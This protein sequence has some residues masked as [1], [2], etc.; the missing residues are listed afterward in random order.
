MLQALSVS[1]GVG[2]TG[3][4]TG[5]PPHE[6]SLTN[7]STEGQRWSCPL[8]W[9]SIGRPTKG[10]QNTM[11]FGSFCCHHWEQNRIFCA[12]GKYILI[13]SEEIDMYKYTL[14]NYRN[15]YKIYVD[16]HDYIQRYTPCTSAVHWSTAVFLVIGK[17]CG[18]LTCFREQTKKSVQAAS[19]PSNITKRQRHTGYWIQKWYGRSM[20]ES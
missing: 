5:F 4:N 10:N 18:T 14:L 19:I 7:G 15:A 13:A 1:F 6:P 12:M 8:F 20:G 9:E 11:S 17:Q 16:I 2:N 3:F